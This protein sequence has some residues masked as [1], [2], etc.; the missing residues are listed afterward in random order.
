MHALTFRDQRQQ[1]KPRERVRKRR[2]IEGEWREGG[3]KIEIK[4]VIGREGEALLEREINVI[5]T[6]LS[7]LFQ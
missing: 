3:R 4:K 6:F 2:K 1:T 7:R 5:V